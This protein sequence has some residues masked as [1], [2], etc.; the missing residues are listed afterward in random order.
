MAEESLDSNNCHVDGGGKESTI[1]EIRLHYEVKGSGAQP[2]ICIPGALG[3]AKM[4]FGPQLDYFGREGSGFKIVSFDPR[5][6]G[7]SRPAE[8]F[9]GNFFEIDA[10]DANA[11]MQSLS[12][13]KFSVLGWSDGGMAALHLASMFPENV[14]QLV[15]CG[16]NAYVTKDDIELYEKVRDISNWDAKMQ[17]DLLRVYGQ[18]LQ[19]L[20]SRWIDAVTKILNDEGGDICMGELSKIK[21]DTLIIHGA[22][23]DLV[24]SLHAHYLYEHITGSRLEVIE[25]GNHDLHLVYSDKF[26]KIVE[27]FLSNNI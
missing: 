3:T 15:I 11:L 18:S 16:S 10:K 25:E 27:D 14:R 6:Y 13:P 7:A 8:R 12:L 19:A 21:C 22:K 20:W 9:D 2:V 26:N 23:D 4:D 1:N 5:G 17:N 24:P